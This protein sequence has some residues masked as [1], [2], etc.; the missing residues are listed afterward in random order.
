MTA[1]KAAPEKTPEEKK[2]E[3]LTLLGAK[4]KELREAQGLSLD[5]AWDALKIQKK[6]LA[7][8]EE[9]AL[10]KLPKG[11]FCRSFLRQYCGY[12]KAD[13]LWK[14]YDKLTGKVNEA[15]KAYKK[16]EEEASYTSTPK[17]FRH[18][19]FF[20]LYLIIALSLGSAA[21]VT[22][23][24]R[25]DIRLNA[26]TPMDGGTAPIV[27]SQK[28]AEETAP[29]PKLPAALSADASADAQQPVD[30]GWMDGKAPAPKQAALNTASPDAS[31]D[32]A[33]KSADVSGAA[34]LRIS[35]TGTVWLKA[36]VGG[37]TLYE[38]LL[39]QGETKEFSPDGETPLRLR[40]G[41]P[42]KTSVSWNG[43]AEAVPGDKA[44]PITKYYW[45]DGQVTDSRKRTNP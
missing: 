44:K 32:A 40:Y 14:R 28:K 6:Y 15:L 24:Y 5:D 12:L 25:G 35:P 31:A 26:T 42:P 19:S 45:S 37:K 13:D 39:K 7:A 2:T 11:P 36:T 29:Q 18:R 33:I 38:G 20:W 8:I 30:L 1:P 23:Q 22:W 34:T 4:L 3:E 10:D 41:N 9:G 16:E 17:V 21:W 43:E 27:E